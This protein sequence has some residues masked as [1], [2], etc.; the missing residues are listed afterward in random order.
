MRKVLQNPECATSYQV[1]VALER[2]SCCEPAG[3]GVGEDYR[4]V[5]VCAAE[6]V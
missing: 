1:I 2:F 6:L 3:V 4:A 5:L